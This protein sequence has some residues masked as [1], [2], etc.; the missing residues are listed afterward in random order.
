M[1][2][3]FDS[4]P[5]F[6]SR[7]PFTFRFEEKGR[8]VA[9]RELWNSGVRFLSWMKL[10]KTCGEKRGIAE[11]PGWMNLEELWEVCEVKSSKICEDF[12]RCKPNCWLC[13]FDLLIQRSF[14]A[15]SSS[16]VLV[17]RTFCSEQASKHIFNRKPTRKQP[18]Q[19][20]F[21]FVLVR[22]LRVSGLCFI[23]L[24]K[25]L[26]MFLFAKRWSHGRTTVAVSWDKLEVLY[27]GWAVPPPV[28][29]VGKRVLPT[30]VSDWGDFCL[31]LT[32]RRVDIE[33]SHLR[34]PWYFYLQNSVRT[35]IEV[36]QWSKWMA[37]HLTSVVR[38]IVSQLV[39]FWE[40]CFCW[41]PWVSWNCWKRFGG[42]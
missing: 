1:D 11:R 32:G 8:L 9:L 26:V 7:V 22:P 29:G 35:V 31:A 17:G 14:W 20:F 25:S 37:N 16:D 21:C 5:G 23:L 24:L 4:N 10:P 38:T 19:P 34:W 33:I 2:T 42:V 12:L 30:F 28:H 36:F 40:V 41:D 3:F 6:K 18:T 15:S 13:W 27:L 39:D